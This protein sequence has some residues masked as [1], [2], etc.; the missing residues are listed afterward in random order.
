MVWAGSSQVWLTSSWFWWFLR[1]M[2]NFFMI[3]AISL[4]HGR[5]LFVWGI[6]LGMGRFF[7]AGRVSR[8]YGRFFRKVGLLLRGMGGFFV[9]WTA[10]C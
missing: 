4:R 7:V 1:G 9:V 2:V 3:W 5:F 8:W 6:Y 10:S